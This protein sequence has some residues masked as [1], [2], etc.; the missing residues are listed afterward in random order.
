MEDLGSIAGGG[1]AE[2]KFL[3]LRPKSRE[4]TYLW[5]VSKPHALERGR[6]MTS[7]F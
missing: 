6:R 5:P 2:K 4:E 1:K 3:K 7:G